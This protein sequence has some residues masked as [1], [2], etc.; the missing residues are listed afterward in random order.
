MQITLH[1]PGTNVPTLLDRLVQGRTLVQGLDPL[2]DMLVQGCREGSRGCR[3]VPAG[4]YMLRAALE[5]THFFL[6]ENQ[7]APKNDS[8]F[9]F[10]VTRQTAMPIQIVPRFCARGYG[11]FEKLLYRCQNPSR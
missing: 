2:L 10:I 3:G 8:F 9:G 1:K 7:H 4:D 11:R 6:G 5:V